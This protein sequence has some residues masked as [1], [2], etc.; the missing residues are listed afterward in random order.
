MNRKAAPRARLSR[1]GIVQAA[2]AFIDEHGATSLSMR[3][4]GQRLGVEAMSLYRYVRGR[5]DLLEGVVAQLL[6]EVERSVDDPITDHWQGYLQTLAHEMR[7]IAIEHPEAFPLVATRHPAAPWLRPPLRSLELVE[8][9]IANLTGYGFTDGQ[10]AETYRAFSSFL[11]GNLL[12]ESAVRG[13]DTSPAEQPLDEGDATVPNADGRESTG[14]QPNINRLRPLLSEDRS[15]EE[16]ETS[17][18]TLL[19]RLDVMLSQ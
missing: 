14:K 8:S 16:F 4:L 3:A 9:F 19:D 18:E 2:I 6:H 17:L 13:A 10:I 5:E 1:E 15:R 7:E 12:L 11:L